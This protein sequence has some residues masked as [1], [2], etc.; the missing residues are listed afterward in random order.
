[1]KI[2]LK[3]LEVLLY[4]CQATNSNPDRGQ[5]F[6]MGW[7]QTSASDNHH[8]QSHEERTHNFLVNQPGI[9]VLPKHIQNITG[10]D[11]EEFLSALPLKEIWNRLLESAMAVAAKNR[12]SLCPTIIHFARYEE[13]FLRR[14]SEEFNPD[15]EFPLQIICTHQIFCRL[16]P[17]LPR[18]GLR[19]VAG[20]FGSSVSHVR[21][22]QS[23]IQGTLFIWKHIVSLL[24]EQENIQTLGQLMDW[25][26]NSPRSTP[27]KR[28]YP[29]DEDF[30][31]DLPDLPGIYRLFRTSGDLLYV[32]KAKSLKRRVNS[33]FQ[34]GK[35][36]EHILDMLS[37]AKSLTYSITPTVFQAAL[38]ETDE[39]KALTPSFNIAL[40]VLDEG[41]FFSTTDLRSL[42]PRPDRSFRTG[43][44]PKKKYIESL[45]SLSDILNDGKPRIHP[46]QIDKILGT[47]D[48]YRPQADIFLQG[49]KEFRRIYKDQL[50]F[51]V[52]FQTLMKFGSWLWKDRLEKIAEIEREAEDQE[53]TLVLKSE[54]K[55][56]K[57]KQTP[58][59]S[60]ES[61]V[62][63]F[64]HTV[65][66]GTYMVRRARWFYLLTESSLAW[67][68]TGSEKKQKNLVIFQKGQP[69]Y[70]SPIPISEPI[71][72]PPGCGKSRL[73]KQRNFD[74]FTYDRMR[75]VNTEIRR[76]L[77]EDRI[78]ELSFNKESV[79][80]SEQLKK[81]LQWI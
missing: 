46:Q 38:R 18:K 11:P 81:I 54:P 73:E 60:P 40:R 24:E 30:R 25:L 67:E 79:Y 56:K 28:E 21:R 1:M 31:K 32:G 2:K 68:K 12:M 34:K 45:S 9:K 58:S 69:F 23:H 39:I 77:K 64:A 52:T 7:L 16:F 6:E 62:K 76:I 47:T 10:I 43:P 49:I 14:F 5:V 70:H 26:E 35:H 66:V 27:A 74:L 37:Q 51:P 44:I 29:M 4:D 48:E 61:L 72:T 80:H 3:D 15:L 50:K 75:I 20:Y 42:R 36:S 63:V 13:S 22:S 41:P 57:K 65:R 78:V 55:A 33:Y 53:E 19:A 8:V 71:P 59:W 17:G